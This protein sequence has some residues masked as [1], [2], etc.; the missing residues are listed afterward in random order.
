MNENNEKL[1]WNVK[2][3]KKRNYKN[4]FKRG[5]KSYLLLVLTV[6]VFSR[7]YFGCFVRFCKCI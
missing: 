5:I 2:E 1:D 4:V 3:L 7:K 6:F